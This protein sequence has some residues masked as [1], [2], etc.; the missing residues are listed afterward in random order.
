[1][2]GDRLGLDGGESDVPI[3]ASEASAGD[4]GHSERQVNSDEG[5]VGTDLPCQCGEGVPPADPD[6]EDAFAR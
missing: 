6:L 1:M 4:L 5:V 3:F 2:A